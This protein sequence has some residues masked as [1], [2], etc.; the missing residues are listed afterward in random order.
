MSKIDNTQLHQSQNP[1]ELFDS[2]MDDRFNWRNSKILRELFVFITSIIALIGIIF[3]ILYPNHCMS[4][5]NPFTNITNTIEK[6]AKI[7]AI[8]WYTSDFLC[9]PFNRKINCS[10]GS[11]KFQCELFRPQT[12]PDDAMGYLFDAAALE[13]MPLPRTPKTVWGL[14]HYESPVSRIMFMYEEALNL[15]N[16][17]ATYSRY[18]DVP[19]P[20]MW[21][22]NEFSITT[23]MYFVPTAEKNSYLSKYAPVLYLQSNCNSA[24]ERDA[25]VQK[26]MQYIKVDSYGFCL[27]NKVLPLGKMYGLPEESQ[28]TYMNHIYGQELLK[29][30]ARYKFVI[31][32]ENAVCND[33]V[34][35]K[36]WRAIEVG[37][38]PIYYGSPL[39]RDWLPNNKS[40]IL[41]EDFPTPELLSQHLHYL[42]NN[43]TAY[44]E[45]LEHKTLALVTN[46]NLLNE[47]GANYF[48]RDITKIIANLECLVCERLHE[49]SDRVNIVTKKHY[50]CPLPTSALTLSVNPDNLWM[51][52]IKEAKSTLDEMIEEIKNPDPNI[53]TT[54]TAW[55]S[56]RW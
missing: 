4:L 14:L 16:F 29:F 22:E 11:R 51:K 42:L 55:L 32:I 13:A 26:L 36:F 25:Y 45:Y 21:M 8:V 52:R 15:F 33:Y 54:K 46:P 47:F 19:S 23:P 9:L 48:Q 34:T 43:D 18:S 31:S 49:D 35:E 56:Y 7:P 5:Y 1:Q 17:S 28:Y 39:I 10:N 20:F 2:Y 6:E 38:V 40:A 41:L 3:W 24:T 30:I 27:H 44:E 37:T 12:Q 53:R 50:D